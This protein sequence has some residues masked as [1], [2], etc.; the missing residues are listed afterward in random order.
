MRVLDLDKGNISR[1]KFGQI[2]LDGSKD[3][4]DAVRWSDLVLATGS[5][6]VNDT[7]D[8][9]LA[10]AGKDKVIFYGVTIAGAASLLNLNR[11][12]FS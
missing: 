3:M 12:C 10:L 2:I 8:E 11:I 4:K 6:L 5:T 9:I 1:E 7:I